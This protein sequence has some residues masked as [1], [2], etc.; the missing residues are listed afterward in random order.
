[1]KS[2]SWRLAMLIMLIMVLMPLGL[3]GYSYLRERF[4]QQKLLASERALLTRLSEQ[5]TSQ[6]TALALWLSGRLDGLR[7][8]GQASRR[9]RE[10]LWD[11]VWRLELHHSFPNYTF[12]PAYQIAQEL[13]AFRPRPLQTNL[14]SDLLKLFEEFAKLQK[15]FFILDDNWDVRYRSSSLLE[16]NKTLLTLAQPLLASAKASGAQEPEWL[17][18][19]LRSPLSAEATWHLLAYYASFKPNLGSSWTTWLVPLWTS[20]VAG[21]LTA[22]I[23]FYLSYRHVERPLKKLNQ[24]LKT[25]AKAI[26]SLNRQDVLG[27]LSRELSRWSQKLANVSQENQ[28]KASAVFSQREVSQ[29]GLEA[30]AIG[31]AV[32]QDTLD[33]GESTQKTSDP[34]AD[35]IADLTAKRAL[36]LKLDQLSQEKAAFEEKLAT[37]S[38]Q[39]GLS[40]AQIKLKA[41][42]VISGFLDRYREVSDYLE[43]AK[44]HI[45]AAKSAVVGFKISSAEQILNVAH[46]DIAKLAKALE[47]EWQYFYPDAYAQTSSN[48]SKPLTALPQMAKASQEP[49]PLAKANPPKVKMHTYA[50]RQEALETQG[51]VKAKPEKAPTL[52]SQL[53]LEAALENY[54]QDFADISQMTLSSALALSQ[55]PEAALRKF[56]DRLISHAFENILRHSEASHAML[57]L[58]ESDR[59]ELLIV[60]NGKGCES[61]RLESKQIKKL[62]QEA[63]ELGGYLQYA[64]HP[65]EGLILSFRKERL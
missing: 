46:D 1:M 15:D 54:L 44:H 12:E 49:K 43:D 21:L 53:T 48:P 10:Q 28:A 16:D 4:Q 35:S 31:D 60:D 33:I 42:E 45:R 17:Y 38:L 59:L 18:Q 34:T 36:E 61:E 52:K 2:F 9:E 56:L 23:L 30:R 7:L 11:N 5:Q 37:L 24:A 20:L 51:R 47:L 6:H 14:A 26:M 3:L 27:D 57:E 40:E 8:Q 25:D 22:L 13:Q 62:K 64:S 63:S 65:R 41:Q 58:L 50:A 55:E 19:P 32:T 29:A 39:A